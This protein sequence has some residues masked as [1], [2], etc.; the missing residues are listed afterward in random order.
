MEVPKSHEPHGTV[1]MSPQ[2]SVRRLMALLLCG[3]VSQLSF[4]QP[5]STEHPGTLSDDALLDRVE[6]QTIEYF[7]KGAEPVSG[8]ACERVHIDG[9]YP[10][11]DKSVVTSG[12]SGFGVMAILAGIDR[13]FIARAAGVE[14]LAQMVNWIEKADRFHGVCPHWWD[15]PTGGVKPFGRKDDGGDLVETAYLFQGLLCARQYFAEGNDQERQLAAAIDRLWREVEWD[16]HRGPDQELVLYWHWSPNFGWQM[17]H[18]IEG[19]NECLI[20]YVLAASSPTHAVPAD[21]YHQGWALSGAIVDDAANSLGLGHRGDRSGKGG[22]LFWAHYSFLGLDPRQLKDRYADYWE[23]NRK[24]VLANYEYCVENPKHY[25]GY[26]PDC[27]GLT[28]SYSTR[29]YAAHCP[30]NDLG[31]ISPT[32]AV[33]SIPYTPRESM[34]AIRHFYE[35]LGDGLNGP[36]GFY[37]AFDQQLD[38]FPRRY[39]AIDQGPMAVMI[40]NYRS[41]LLW[42]LFMSAP[43]VQRGLRKLDFQFGSA[44]AAR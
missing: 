38:W 28:A 37:D 17:R 14:R 23:H 15:G 29:F 13:G 20:T 43:E 12:G 16:W 11:N 39:L 40:E 21:V 10:A 31:V 22:P 41:G 33:S 26:G 35:D 19:W 3:V 24:H 8:L 6:Q 27:W 36:Y 7:W 5:K 44:E 25:Y 9:V 32:A 2:Q 30:D 4:A 42:K 18:R 1:L 34:A